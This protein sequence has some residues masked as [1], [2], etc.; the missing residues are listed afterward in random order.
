MTCTTIEM[1]NA[2]PLSQSSQPLH[3]CC[4]EMNACEERLSDRWRP[5]R[6]YWEDAWPSNCEALWSCLAP[7]T[8]AWQYTEG[9]LDAAVTS[10]ITTFGAVR[11]S[12]IAAR[13]VRR[14]LEERRT[15]LDFPWACHAASRPRVRVAATAK[16]TAIIFDQLVPHP[17]RKTC[18]STR[19]QSVRTGCMI[20]LI[21][22]F[23]NA[24]SDIHSNGGTANIGV[25]K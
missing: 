15:R 12:R 14:L 13:I 17:V 16:T 9:I 10:S 1:A 11:R 5:I 7:E 24:F 4:R 3:D 18:P 20:G 23:V 22:R 25:A 21:D 19:R 6:A 8:T 2:A